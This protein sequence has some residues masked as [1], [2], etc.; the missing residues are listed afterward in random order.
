MEELRVKILMILAAIGSTEAQLLG[1]WDSALQT[2][3]I[4]MAVDYLTG[5][6]VAGV[7]KKSPKSETGA[8]K[9]KVGFMG[10]CK[11]GVILMIVLVGVR[12]DIMLGLGQFIRNAIVI[13]FCFN[14]LVSIVENT[15]LMIKLPP[16]IVQ[17]VDILK[18]KSEIKIPGGDHDVQN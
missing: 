9:S 8:M 16:V 7:F 14:E 13:G 15:G 2:L 3:I 6:I 4:F 11:K 1:G 5:L 17:A 12:L 10:L 18:K